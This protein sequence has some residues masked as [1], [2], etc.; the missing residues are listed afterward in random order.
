MSSDNAL[1]SP[2]T[3]DRAPTTSLSKK[4]PASM[5]GSTQTVRSEGGEQQPDLPASATGSTQTIRSEVGGPRPD[6]SERFVEVV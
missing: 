5:A 1:V 4:E 2:S 6:L 3:S